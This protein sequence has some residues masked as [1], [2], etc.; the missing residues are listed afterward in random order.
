M[1]PRTMDAAALPPLTEANDATAKHGASP[2]LGWAFWL[3]V[4][5]LALVLACAAGATWMPIQDPLVIDFEEQAGSPGAEHW[6]GTDDLGRD[7]FSRVVHGSHISMIVGFCAPLIALVLGT[8]FGVSA[9]YFRGRWE[10]VVVMYADTRLAFEEKRSAQF[11]REIHRGRQ[12]AVGDILP[13]G[14][15]LEGSVDGIGC[16]LQTFVLLRRNESWSRRFSAS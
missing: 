7:I 9:G 2:R 15:E 3:A 13:L 8:L 16:L 5:W 14:E 4:S 11:E 12:A 10:T 6:L 1:K